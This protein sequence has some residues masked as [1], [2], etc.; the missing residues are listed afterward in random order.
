VQYSGAAS[1]GVVTV[2]SR[3]PQDTGGEALCNQSESRWV[4]L[5]RG[6]QPNQRVWTSE[7]VSAPAGPAMGSCSFGIGSAYVAGTQGL[8]HATFSAILVRNVSTTTPERVEVSCE[9]YDPYYF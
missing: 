5:V 1:D 8:Y 3:G 2:F 9:V 4:R 7:F 6:S